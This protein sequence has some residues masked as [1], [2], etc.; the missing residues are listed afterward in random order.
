MTDKVEV[1]Q[2]HVEA[3]LRPLGLNLE[4]ISPHLHR[5]I[6][7]AAEAL[8]E[9]GAGAMRE[10]CLDEQRWF[11]ALQDDAVYVSCIRAIDPASVK[12]VG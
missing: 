6:L 9:A 3:I 2:D 4:H 5:P 7:A 12:E 10:K 1:I 8:F 11:E